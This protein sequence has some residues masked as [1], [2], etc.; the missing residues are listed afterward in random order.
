MICAYLGGTI[1]ILPNA[2]PQLIM[3]V[4][5]RSKHQQEKK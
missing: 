3:A 1:A 5:L 2:E 4:W